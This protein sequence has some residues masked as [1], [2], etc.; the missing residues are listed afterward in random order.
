MHIKDAIRGND[1]QN[2]M[3]EGNII[4]RCA[5]ETHKETKNKGLRCSGKIL[6]KCSEP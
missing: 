3:C 4:F 2:R 6:P 1:A 5:I